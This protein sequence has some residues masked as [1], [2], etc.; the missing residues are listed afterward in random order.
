MANTLLVRLFV[1]LYLI[2]VKTAE[3]M[4]PTN[5]VGSIDLREGLWMHKITKICIQK[6]LI[7]V[8]LKNA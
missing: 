8:K 4:G 3:P 6:F 7:F 5:F 1:C 2:N